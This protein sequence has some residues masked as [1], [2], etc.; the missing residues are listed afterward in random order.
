MMYFKEQFSSRKLAV[1]L[2]LLLKGSK[3]SSEIKGADTE[4]KRRGERERRERERERER[5]RLN[6]LSGP[7]SLHPF[8]IYL[9]CCQAL[10][11]GLQRSWG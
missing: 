10:L 3:V 9:I 5:G 11:W 4:R 7:F 2:R 6:S 1:I 8:S